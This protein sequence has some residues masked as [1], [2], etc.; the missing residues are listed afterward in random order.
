MLLQTAQA[1]IHRPTDPACGMTIRLMFDGGSQRSYIS[2]RVKE[3][4][5][6]ETECTEVV[7]IKTFGSETTKTQTVDVVTASIHTKEGNQMN[8]LFSTVPLIR[9][10]L[11]CQPVA[12]TKQQYRHLSGLDLADYSRVGDELQIDALIGS[13][14]YWQLVTGTVL[15]GESGPTAIHTQLGWI[16]SG[17]VGSTSDNHPSASLPTRHSLHITHSS[18]SSNSLDKSLKAFW[19]LESLG[20]KQDEPS[21]YEEFTKNIEFKNGRYEVSLPWKPSQ[22]KLPSNFTLAKK[23]LKGLLNRLNHNPDVKMEYHAVIQDQLRQGIIEEVT[24][25]PRA[26]V[27]GKVHY[28]PHHAIIRKDKQ[29]TKLRI[30]YDASAR[31][32]GGSLNDSTGQKVA[33]PK[34]SFC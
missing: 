9:E 31:S 26:N 8:I 14:H 22:K 30:V 25:D 17:P 24:E 11:S 27:N 16:L 5:G 13:D 15:H 3:A 7:N 32:E 23:H 20:I 1:Y 12:Y 28:L 10:P 21:V 2:E 29:T 18:D 34:C 33:F 19:E 6:L 4:L